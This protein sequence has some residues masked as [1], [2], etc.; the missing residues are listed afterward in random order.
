MSTPEFGLVCITH[1]T[2]VRFRTLTLTR[3][4][5]FPVSAR[6]RILDELYRHNLRVLVRAIEYCAQHGF[7]LYRIPSSLFPLADLPDG[8]GLSIL[9]EFRKDLSWVGRHALKHGVRL[10]MHPDQYV[11]LNSLSETV[12]ENSVQVL[13]HL[14][15]LMDWM[16]LARSPWAALNIHGGKAGRLEQLVDTITH[17]PPGVRSRLTLE[18]DERTYGAEDILEVCQRTGVPMVFD[19]HHHLVREHLESFEDPSLGQYLEAAGRTWP[20]PEWQ[21]VHLSNGRSAP[22][23]PAH[24]DLIHTVPSCLRGVPW[25]EVEAKQKEYAIAHLRAQWDRVF[26]AYLPVPPPHPQ[27]EPPAVLPL[28]GPPLYSGGRNALD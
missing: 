8:V 28:E 17:L 11:A 4:K 5:H 18:N 21:I 1:S 25:L 9:E 12:I 13:E 23:D 3:Y 16:G 22:H 6:V 27:P 15:R 24:H 10:V 19:L 7:G 20:H 2:A 26:A 14:A